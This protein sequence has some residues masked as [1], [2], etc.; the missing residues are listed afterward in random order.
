LSYGIDYHFNLFI[1]YLYRFFKR[2]AI[3]KDKNRGKNK[4]NNKEETFDEFVDRLCEYTK[5]DYESDLLLIK[6][7]E[8]KGINKSMLDF[9]KWKTSQ[10]KPKKPA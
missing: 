9:L 4:M 3:N 7:F 1:V 10:Y 6:L 2:T 5:E 8:T